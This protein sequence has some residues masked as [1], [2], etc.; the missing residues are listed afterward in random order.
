M[1][2]QDETETVEYSEKCRRHYALW[3]SFFG[4]FG[5]H[6]FYAGYKERGI[7]KLL[8]WFVPVVGWFAVWIWWLIDLFS[9]SCDA[10]GRPLALGGCKRVVYILLCVFLGVGGWHHLYTGHK[11]RWLV[12]WLILILLPIVGRLVVGLGLGLASTKSSIESMM[13]G[14]GVVIVVLDIAL[15][16]IMWLV[17]LINAILTTTDADG[18]EIA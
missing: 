11:L 3:W 13:W 12:Q 14:A 1:D 4:M 17:S 6:D 9:V 15:I 7:I 8:L 5:A 16:S 2:S 10:K 18:C